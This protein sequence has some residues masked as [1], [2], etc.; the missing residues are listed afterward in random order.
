MTEESVSDRLGRL[1]GVL[2]A[3]LAM[4]S[5]QHIRT[6]AGAAGFEV[7]KVPSTSESRTGMGSRNEVLPGLDRIFEALSTATKARVLVALSTRLLENPETAEQ[8]QRL[9]EEQGFGI[10]NGSVVLE[11]SRSDAD[12]DHHTGLLSRR[13][14]D[15]DLPDAIA[16][17]EASGQPV[18]LVTFDIDHFKNV[19]DDHGGHATGDE[20]LVG[21]AKLSKLC[22]G[23]KGR[24]YRLG[25]DEFALILPNHSTNEAVAVAERL[26]STVE[27]TPLTSH[28]LRLS[29]SI[30][31]AEYP[32]HGDTIKLVSERAD[33]AV[34]DAKRLGRNLVRA[35]GE[36]APEVPQAPR[37]PERR[38][39][40]P[41]GLTQDQQD[42]I[43]LAY[44]RDGIARCPNDD[45]VLNIENTTGMGQKTDSIYVNCP[46]CGLLVE[47]D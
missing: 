33:A 23:G 9:V 43:R 12:V 22:V 1:W 13:A 18:A 41:G 35:Y 25:G 30:G 5:V 34:Y 3:A 29:L 47:I 45:A 7:S 24:A 46:V 8:T 21:V 6:T 28:V 2:R 4:L 20:A 16:E 31:V 37:E 10:A 26:R 11:A 38:Q 15:A 42:S 17:A 44:F 39:P 32:T 19:N 36:P 14:F 27:H 40:V